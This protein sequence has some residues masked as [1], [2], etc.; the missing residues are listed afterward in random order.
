MAKHNAKYSERA[1]FSMHAHAMFDTQA[2]CCEAVGQNESTQK[3]GNGIK[4]D[5]KAGDPGSGSKE[6]VNVVMAIQ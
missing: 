5:R 6:A 2:A 1:C 3:V 4:Q